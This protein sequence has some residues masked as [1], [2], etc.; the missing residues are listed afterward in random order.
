MSTWL[1]YKSYLG[2][3]YGAT[4]SKEIFNQVEIISHM[5]TCPLLLQCDS[6]HR[7]ISAHMSNPTTLP[8]HLMARM[9]DYSFQVSS[10][11]HQCRRDTIFRNRQL[12]QISIL[13]IFVAVQ[14]SRR[15]GPFGIQVRVDEW[16]RLSDKAVGLNLRL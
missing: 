2:K 9:Y 6:R 11:H 10:T 12:E 1:D 16:D 5:S 7:S 4:D 3:T 8:L 15:K 14:S 13:S